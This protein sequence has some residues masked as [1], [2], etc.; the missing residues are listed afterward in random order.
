MGIPTL[1]ASQIQHLCLSKVQSMQSRFSILLGI[2]DT[3]T[4]AQRRRS[5]VGGTVGKLSRL[6]R[7]DY[8]SVDSVA[9]LCEQLGFLPR[10]SNFT[11]VFSDGESA[12]LNSCSFIDYAHQGPLI[13]SSSSYRQPVAAAQIFCH[14]I[15]PPTIATL[16][17]RS[18]SRSLPL[19]QH[20]T[21]NHATPSPHLSRFHCDR[22]H[23]VVGIGCGR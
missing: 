9:C 3:R 8:F 11:L 18:Q 22:S 15:A 19:L 21:L 6:S 13:Q 20:T 10:H 23:R 1:L 12:S 2:P 17:A 5:S 14:H 7:V 16:R 4:V